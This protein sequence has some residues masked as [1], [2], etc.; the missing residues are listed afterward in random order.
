MEVLMQELFRTPVGLLS[1][2]TIGFI[3][4][5]AAWLFNFVRK[6]VAHD[7]LAHRGDSR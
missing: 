1:L 2:A 7:E 3:V 4:I 5:M 6:N